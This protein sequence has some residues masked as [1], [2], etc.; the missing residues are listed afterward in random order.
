MGC[1]TALPTLSI[2]QHHLE[3]TPTTTTTPPPSISLTFADYNPTVLHL[4]TLPNI[5]LTWARHHSTTTTSTAWA[6]EGDLEITPDLLSTFQTSLHSRKISLNF[7]SG[8]WSPEFVQN[9]QTISPP[10]NPKNDDKNDDKDN[11]TNPPLLILA[12]ETI[13][14][15]LALKTFTSSLMSILEGEIASSSTHVV[16]VAMTDSISSTEIDPMPAL[17]ETRAASTALVAAKKVYFGVGGS[18]EDFC[19][20]VR[21]RGAEVVGVREE[22]DGVRRAVVE[23]R[24]N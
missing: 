18:M 24:L 1:G 11:D 20:G 4:V 8:A 9:F 12:A 13:Y 23:V 15:P 14:S 5:L 10:S 2:L 3:N 17:R 22:S 21:A 6:P 7:L 16:A 19:E